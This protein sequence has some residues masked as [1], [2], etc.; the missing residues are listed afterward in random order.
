VSVKRSAA[1]LVVLAV[2]LLLVTAGQPAS[3]R[4]N[5]IAAAKQRAHRLRVRLAQLE[6]SAA[7]AVGRYEATQAALEVAVAEHMA[8]QTALD[9]AEVESTD[10][11]DGAVNRVRALYMTGGTMA[12]YASVLDATDP[13]DA[14]ARIANISAVVDNDAE[15]ASDAS[16]RL[17]RAEA[18]TSRL[19]QTALARVKLEERAAAEASAIQR[20]LSK[21]ERLV[22]SADKR[23]RALLRAEQ[24]RIERARARAR[25]REAARLARLRGSS[26]GDRTAPYR[27]A[28]GRYSCPVGLNSH[29]VDTWHAPRSGGRL[30]QGTDV[31]APYG[32]PAYAVTAG[33]IDQW[34]NGGLGGITLWLRADNGD[35]YY[36]AHNSRNVARVGT[37]VSPGQV[38]AYVGNTGNARTT[39]PHIHFEAHPGGG[40]AANPYPFLA[41]ICGKV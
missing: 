21:Q 33:V 35:R 40:A 1:R 18:A 4:P 12:M 25:A 11:E 3:A 9:A 41:A 27:P 13:H 28:G 32:S 15:T 23:V 22:A 34:G 37:R 24:R 10:A 29:F 14:F 16:T 17:D 20:L 30:H 26:S 2:A 6:A 5:G 19:R 8:A 38:I 7:R 36:Y 39:P 31:F